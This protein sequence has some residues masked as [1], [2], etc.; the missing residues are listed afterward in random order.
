MTTRYLSLRGYAKRI[1]IA[2]STIRKY[3]IEKR[4]AP[5][6]AI[7]GEGN[8]PTHG[9]LPETID[10]WQINRPGQGAR[11]DLKKNG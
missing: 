9:W 10:T 11:T 6:D 3:Q 2:Y 8:S 5:P 4:L 1:G 7:I